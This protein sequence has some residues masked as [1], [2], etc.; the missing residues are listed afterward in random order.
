MT[1]IETMSTKSTPGFATRVLMDDT[2]GQEIEEARGLALVDFGADWCSPCRTM[3]PIIEVLAQ[4]Y[5]GHVLIG[6]IDVDTSQRVTARYGVWHFPT[7][8]FFRDGRVVERIVGA[9]PA[10]RLRER[11]AALFGDAPV[12]RSRAGG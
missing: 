1:T 7:F 6:A 9:V 11:L 10:S 8:L 4:E 2:F 3:A 12:S 5:A